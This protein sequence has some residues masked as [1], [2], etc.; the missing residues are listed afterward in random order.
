MILSIT[1][2]D[3]AEGVVAGKYRLIAVSGDISFRR[4]VLTD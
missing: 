2:E 1:P 3:V 4:N